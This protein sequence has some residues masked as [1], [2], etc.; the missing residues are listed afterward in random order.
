MTG[1]YRDLV[2]RRNRVECLALPALRRR[3]EE[4]EAEIRSLREQ[5]ADAGLTP[6][7]R[8]LREALGSDFD[9]LDDGL[10]EKL[11]SLVQVDR[12][13]GN[14]HAAPNGDPIG[15]MDPM[16]RDVLDREMA[17]L[18]ES[19]P[20]VREGVERFDLLDAVDSLARDPHLKRLAGEDADG[21]IRSVFDEAALRVFGRR[22]ADSAPKEKPAAR[23]RKPSVAAGPSR[24]TPNRRAGGLTPDEQ[25]RVIWNE[26]QKGRSIQ[27]ARKAAGLPPEPDA[28]MYD[29]R[30]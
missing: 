28:R 1:F 26:M 30:S 4:Q 7:A 24:T 10:K 2:V 6:E 8:R 16:R 19:F 25:K 27:Q 21:W 5:L 18:G 17:R 20:D 29:A 12:R 14:G 22:P 23:K 9:Q 3:A 15:G 11:S 13:N